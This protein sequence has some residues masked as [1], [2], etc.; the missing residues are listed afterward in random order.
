MRAAEE[1]Y[2][3]G[4]RVYYKR[5]EHNRWLRLGKVVFQDGKIVFVRHGGNFVRVSP[6]RLIRARREFAPSGNDESD[7]DLPETLETNSEKCYSKPTEHEATGSRIR[8]IA[9][10]EEVPEQAEAETDSLGPQG[11]F[12]AGCRRDTMSRAPTET[13]LVRKNDTI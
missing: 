2:Q 9:G 7:S 11:P 5:E 10:G 1:V 3:H 6:S 8:G 12:V 13:I 4:D